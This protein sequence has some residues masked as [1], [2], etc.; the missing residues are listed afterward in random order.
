MCVWVFVRVFVCV[1]VHICVGVG[2]CFVCIDAA[3]LNTIVNT[4]KALCRTYLLLYF[5][6]TAALLLLYWVSV[7]VSD[8]NTGKALSTLPAALLLLYLCFIS[9]LLLLYFC[10]TSRL[11]T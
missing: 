3:N 10:F 1:C 8:V 11:A 6:F 2:V 4:G 9:A 5:C 7:Q